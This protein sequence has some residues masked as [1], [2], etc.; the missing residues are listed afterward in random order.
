MK[1][2]PRREE[3]DPEELTLSPQ[4]TGV[5]EMPRQWRSQGFIAT[6]LLSI[7]T[8][9]CNTLQVLNVLRESVYKYLERLFWL[10]LWFSQTEITG[11]IAHM[12][13]H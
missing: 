5:Y 12:N 8:Q 10:A 1:L 9:V 11:W 2:L 13:S 3:K 7:Y 6:P 4:G